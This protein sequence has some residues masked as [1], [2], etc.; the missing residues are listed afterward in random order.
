VVLQS[1]LERYIILRTSWVFSA[2]GNNFVKTM[3]RL[4]SERDD[5]DSILKQLGY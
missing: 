1:M 5:L 2:T 3:L 4:G